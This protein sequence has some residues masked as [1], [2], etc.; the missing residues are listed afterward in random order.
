MPASKLKNLAILVLVLANLSL[1]AI[2]IP[3]HM[4]QAQENESMR[5]SLQS[6]YAAQSITLN[7]TWYRTR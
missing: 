7:R 6:L 2:L 4:N 5:R 1:L 3:N